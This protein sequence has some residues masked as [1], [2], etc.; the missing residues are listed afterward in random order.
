MSPVLKSEIG[1]GKINFKSIINTHQYVSG[2]SKI[3]IWV[4][5]T[6]T[7]AI[8]TMPEETKKL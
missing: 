8:G 6:L 5:L 3:I 4:S 1:D 2:I 7:K